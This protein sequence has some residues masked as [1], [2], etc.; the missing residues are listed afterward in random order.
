[1]IVV[2]TSLDITHFLGRILFCSQHHNRSS[3]FWYKSFIQSRFGRGIC[4]HRVQVELYCINMDVR[5][6]VLLVY[7]ML[8]QYLAS[9][10]SE[11][12]KI[13]D[14]TLYSL[15]SL[16][17]LIKNIVPSISFQEWNRM[18]SK[19]EEKTENLLSRLWSFLITET[20][21]CISLN[22]EK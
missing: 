11:Y 8:K 17:L 14:N 19:E 2:Q 16:P 22:Y 3:Q 15:S 1:M 4:N 13:H 5:W 10:S 6:Q 20:K 21:N 12:R 9:V 7:F 18:E